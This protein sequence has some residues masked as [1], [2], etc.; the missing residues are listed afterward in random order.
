[1]LIGFM[2]GGFIVFTLVV[3]FVVLVLFPEWVGVSGRDHQ[4][5]LNEQKGETPA[6]PT[7]DGSSTNS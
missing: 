6:K 7:E 4:K 3:Y 5:F 2:I 1:M